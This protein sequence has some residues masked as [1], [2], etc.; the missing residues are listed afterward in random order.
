MIKHYVEHLTNGRKQALVI[1]IALAASLAA[2]A[3]AAP[4]WPHPK[5]NMQYLPTVL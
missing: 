2:L 1:V 3:V 5:A 4:A